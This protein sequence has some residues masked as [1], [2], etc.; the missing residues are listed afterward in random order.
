M[1]LRPYQVAAVE[2]IFAAWQ[3]SD[4]TLL[5]LPTGTGKTIV[6]AHVI[7]R[8]VAEGKRCLVLAHRGE[9][10][11]Q[12]RDKLK[13]ST[14]LECAVEK[15]DLSAERSHYRVTVGSVQTLM[16]EDRLAR[17][18]PHHYDAI[19]VDEAHHVLAES[20]QRI[21]SYFED[22]KVLGVTA[23]PD[24]GDLRNLGECFES[25]AFEYSLPR[26]IKDGFLCKIS[27]LTIPLKI[28]LSAVKATAGDLQP[29]SLG[30]ILDPYLE[31]I[32][33]QMIA[34]CLDRKTV[35]FMPLISTSQKMAALLSD[36]GFAV[37]E[38][39]GESRDRKEILGWTNENGEQVP[40]WWGR[41][42][43]G[44]VLCNSMLL[45]EG[46]DS[47]EVDCVVCLRPTK[48]RSLYAQ[49]VGR[50]TRMCEGKKDLLLLDFLWHTGRHELARPAHLICETDEV[51]DAMISR[52]DGNAGVELDLE[53]EKEGAEGDAIDAREM[54]LA[55]QLEALKRRKQKLVDPLQFEM[56]ILDADLANYEPRIGA[57]LN[58]PS[59]G[60]RGRLEQ[61]GILPDTIESAGKAN[62]ILEA[63]DSRRKKGLATPKQIRLLERRGFSHVGQWSFRAAR[64]MIDRMAASGWR[65][66][67]GVNPREYQPE[68]S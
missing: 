4:R 44:S 6:F 33:D 29:K 53:E 20:Y 36:R 42:A 35:I 31:Q 26:A 62:K 51:A 30:S 52:M 17:F 40:G 19:I 14:G 66:P 12:A 57:E 18:S 37:R 32:A 54:A 39:N 46:W 22:A 3:Q 1:H 13:A 24:R 60:Q 56:S 5:V 38:V 11:D 2:G 68:A 48:I 25:I 28:D 7:R 34:H 21:L 67:A 64:S 43:P 50:G 63:L 27:A 61:A 45:T 9:L 49:I 55:K 65:I 59:E 15:A 41:A 16:R 8:L 23:T 47:P 10:L 58:A